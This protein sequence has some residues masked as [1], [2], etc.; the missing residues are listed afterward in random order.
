MALWQWIAPYKL[1]AS[2]CLSVGQAP[3]QGIVYAI[4]KSSV[5]KLPVRY[6]LPETPD[7]QVQDR[8]DST[9][10][11]L[12]LFTKEARLYGLFSKNPHPYIARHLYA[13]PQTVL[14]IERLLPLEDSLKRADQTTR[15]RWVIELCSAVAHLETLGY[16]HGDLAPRNIGTD[17]HSLKLFDFGT[18]MYITDDGFDVMKSGE[19]SALATCIHFILSGVDPFGSVESMEE[20]RKLQRDLAEGRGEV[21]P[22]AGILEEVIQDCWTGRNSA[23]TFATLSQKM[24]AVLDSKG[25][26]WGS[27]TAHQ[28]DWGAEQY[29]RDWLQKARVNPQ[30]KSMEEYCSEWRQLGVEGLLPE[31]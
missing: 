14:F 10:Q 30:W 18:A 2:D 20:L 7:E 11:S 12:E 27:D 31:E 3:S 5:V 13:E 8:F 21:H 15:C 17:G 25:L 1:P 9:L 29:C 26:G 16:I 6:C 28:R 19:Y 24:R 23:T 22:D 4:N